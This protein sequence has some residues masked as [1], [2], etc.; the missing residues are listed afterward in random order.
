MNCT[1]IVVAVSTLI[2]SL[3]LFFCLVLFVS[4]QQ[5]YLLAGFVSRF[6]SMMTRLIRLK[7]NTR[8]FI[9][10]L[11]MKS[12]FFPGKSPPAKDGCAHI[13]EHLLASRNRP[14]AAGYHPC[15]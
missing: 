14:N 7:L 13:N 4:F 6:I 3:F 1:V 9:I 2:F 12:F 5:N 11:I 15:P 8:S 10:S